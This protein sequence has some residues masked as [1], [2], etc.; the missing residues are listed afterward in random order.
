MELS[1]LKIDL[2][3][4]SSRYVIDTSAGTSHKVQVP[5]LARFIE[6]LFNLHIQHGSGTQVF[7]AVPIPRSRV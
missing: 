3:Y 5:E 6:R 2:S 4:F 7:D 1:L